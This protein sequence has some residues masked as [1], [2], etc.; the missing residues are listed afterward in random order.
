[1]SAK[2]LWRVFHR[3]I[4]HHDRRPIKIFISLE[5][6][7]WAPTPNGD[8]WLG[9][10][11]RHSNLSICLLG[12]TLTFCRS[13]LSVKIIQIRNICMY[14]CP[15]YMSKSRGQFN[16]PH[17]TQSGAMT[18][19]RALQSALNLTFFYVHMSIPVIQTSLSPSCTLWPL[20]GLRL[21][22]RAVAVVATF[23]TFFS[24]IAIWMPFFGRVMQSQQRRQPTILSQLFWFLNYYLLFNF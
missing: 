2:K 7:S 6:R 14:V 4:I 1:M 23:F 19:R 24:G 15:I 22:Y 20:R 9:D 10:P 21:S 3:K 17:W 8:W 18:P 12:P 5:T 13:L 16:K 11:N